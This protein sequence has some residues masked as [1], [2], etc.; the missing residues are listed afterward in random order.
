MEQTALKPDWSD[1]P[2]VQA[3]RSKT[4]A[5]SVLQ[6]SFE[7]FG[8]SLSFINLYPA[9]AAA[10]TLDDFV[11]FA[12]SLVPSDTNHSP[13]FRNADT[14]S[15]MLTATSYYGESDLTKN[16]HGLW[17][18]YYSGMLL[19]HAGN[20]NGFSSMLAF[21]P[22]TGLGVVVMTNEQGETAYNYGLLPLIFGDYTPKNEITEYQDISGIYLYKRSVFKGFT[23]MF[24]YTL[25]VPVFK[26][27]EAGMFKQ[28][29][30]DRIYQVADNE[31]MF[32]NGNGQNYLLYLNE[33]NGNLEMMSTDLYKPG[34]P[35]LVISIM[36][37]VAI[38][39]NIVYCFVKIICY[40]HR[41]AKK[42]NIHRLSIMRFI[43]VG[44]CL[45]GA[46]LTV[47]MLLVNE[48]F[49]PVKVMISSLIITVASCVPVANLVVYICNNRAK[50]TNEKRRKY[51]VPMCITLLL[52]VAVGYFQLYDFWSC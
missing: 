41:F 15:K 35:E 11:L 51:I 23:S 34:L 29:G 5:Y 37:I 52:T 28:L 36:L 20:T 47:Y 48:S 45:L 49:T 7:S 33:V 12:K 18:M 42:M 26:K 30:E 32:D 50:L 44:A 6:D 40:I 1:N 27:D 16:A 39:V 3:Q 43:T 24:R 9:G 25:F 8:T 19:G 17:A 21:D 14:L 13:L 38:L 46:T 4:K 2:W 31:F 22:V 10:G